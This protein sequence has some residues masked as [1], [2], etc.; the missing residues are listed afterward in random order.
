MSAEF[1][2]KLNDTARDARVIVREDGI[3]VAHSLVSSATLYF[4]L[5][6]ADGVG[7]GEVYSRPM[8]R[9][10]EVQGKWYYSFSDSDF[11]TL[12]VGEYQAWVRFIYTDGRKSTAPTLGASR[13]QIEALNF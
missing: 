10:P 5:L 4:Q 1:K 2:L 13:L 7:T 6:D 8:L 9:I 11:G 12:P 3:P